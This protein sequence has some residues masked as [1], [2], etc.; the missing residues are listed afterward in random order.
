MTNA[1]LL[2]SDLTDANLSGANLSGTN[3]EGV[4]L[5]GANLTGAKIKKAK[6]LIYSHIDTSTITFSGKKVSLKNE[7]KIKEL[8]NKIDE[9]REYYLQL[10]NMDKTEKSKKLINK[11]QKD[12]KKYQKQLE[13]TYINIL[14]K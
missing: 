11:S 2:I 1:D 10:L 12:K 3:M 6:Y 5:S 8:K 4:D 9:E 14:T 7:S 13:K